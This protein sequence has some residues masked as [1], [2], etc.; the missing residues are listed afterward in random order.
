MAQLGFMFDSS[1][2]IGCKT[3]Q[4]ACKNI[5][6]M[7]VG[8]ILRRVYSYENGTWENA[9]LLSAP[10]DLFAYNVSVSCNHCASPACVENCPTG[11]MQ[12][13]PETGIVW[14]DHEV[15]IGCQTCVASC[16]YGAPSLNSASNLVSK[17]DFCKSEIEKGNDPACVA[18]CPV[19]A[20]EFGDLEELKAKYGEGDCEIE[21]LPS[22]TTGPSLVLIPHPKAV[23]SG[24]GVG[25]VVSLEEEL[26]LG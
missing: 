8:V 21:P 14:N 2:C 3:C 26:L 20:L 13:D 7:P 17:C 25:G 10:S 9:K 11:A 15:C 18:I 12:K 19:R 22:D 24:S 6:D 16:P 5:N 4:I 23:A 1:A